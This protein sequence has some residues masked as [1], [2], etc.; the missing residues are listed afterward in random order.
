MKRTRV[1]YISDEAHKLLR[2]LAAL[3]GAGLGQWVEDRI[4]DASMRDLGD[5]V[6]KVLGDQEEHIVTIP[7]ASSNTSTGN[8]RSMG[9]TKKREDVLDS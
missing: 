4:Y 7:G 6:H 9:E 1:I 2:M 5:E 3:R 8:N